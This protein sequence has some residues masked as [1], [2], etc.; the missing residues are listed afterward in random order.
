MAGRNGEGGSGAFEIRPLRAFIPDTVQ[1][2]TM[3]L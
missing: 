2:E 3:I 1:R